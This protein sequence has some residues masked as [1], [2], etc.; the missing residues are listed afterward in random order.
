MSGR[1]ER[2]PP[3]TRPSPRVRTDGALNKP[4]RSVFVSRDVLR[5]WY[6]AIVQT[7]VDRTG[8]SPPK[9]TVDEGYRLL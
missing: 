7:Y 6:E 9:S 3:V 2:P 4:S 8:D 5:R 1:A